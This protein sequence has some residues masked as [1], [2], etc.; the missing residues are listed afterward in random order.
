[1]S[2]LSHAHLFH[3]FHN[4]ELNRF[5]VAIAI[6]TFG[7]GLIS[8]FVPI[9]LFQIGYQVYSIIF[10]Y[11]LSS[12]SFVLFSFWGAKIVAR[13]GA[14]HSILISLPFFFAVLF[15]FALFRKTD[16]NPTDVSPWKFT[17]LI[18]QRASVFFY[19][20]SHYHTT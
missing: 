16:L 1:M 20:F 3:F 19:I 7:E 10:F 18:L 11:F 6:F 9:Y 12:F 14:K 17:F 15:G 8:I 13:V 5:Y 2:H 4:K